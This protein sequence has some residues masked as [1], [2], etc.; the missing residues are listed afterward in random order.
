VEQHALAREQD[1]A[2]AG[3]AP[4]PPQ[5]AP[6]A[7]ERA[8]AK[9]RASTGPE[10]AAASAPTAE[11]PQPAER[12]SSAAVAPPPVSAQAASASAV[13]QPEPVAVPLVAGVRFDNAI[14]RSAPSPATATTPPPSPAPPAIEPKRLESKPE[15]AKAEPTLTQPMPAPAASSKISAAAQ[16]QNTP[17]ATAPGAAMAS[18]PQEGEARYTL[19]RGILS[20]NV[21]L[22]WKFSDNRYRLQSV[23]QGAGLLAVF[24]SHVQVSEGEVG[25]QGLKPS[26]FSVELRGKKDQAVFL[27][28]AKTIQFSGKSGE[29]SAQLPDGAQDMLSLL[30]QLAFEPPQT[31]Q[32]TSQVTNGRKLETYTF[33]RV[34]EETLELPAGSFRTI[35]V[36]KQHAPGDDAMELWLSPEHHYLPVKIRLID[37]KGEVMEQTVSTIKVAKAGQ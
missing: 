24:G 26:S 35:H 17:P 21:A 13:K 16:S 22:S 18:L 29:R 28:E 8:G 6:T 30:F 19:R 23:A 14:S 1:A 4:I 7:W 15:V 20:A 25:A 33:A 37:R 36:A 10:D 9:I 12:V 27:W 34:G 3:A 32:L 31:Q 5:S 11:P 2:N